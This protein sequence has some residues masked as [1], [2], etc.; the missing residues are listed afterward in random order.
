MKPER[1]TIRVR[2]NDRLPEESITDLLLGLEEEG[3]PVEVS[4]HDELNPLQLAHQA[5]LESRLGIGIGV[6]LDYIVTTTEKLPAERPYLVETLHRS[7][8]TDRVAG[9]NAARLVKRMPLT[10]S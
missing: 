2:L 7:E 4:R 9:S 10:V 5:A 1:P 3:V 6:S 8:A